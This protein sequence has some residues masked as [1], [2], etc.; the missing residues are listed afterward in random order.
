MI[1]A[2]LTAVL[3]SI[4]TGRVDT[5][6][7]TLHDESSADEYPSGHDGLLM[8][9]RPILCAECHA[10]NALGAA[11]V[12]GV[13]SLS[14]AIHDKHEGEVPDSQVGCYECHPGPDT[15]CLR[16]V[17]ST[18]HDMGCVDCHGGMEDVADNP[19]P[20]LNEPRCDTCHDEPG[21]E[22]NQ[23]L[24]R[25]STDHGGLY[26]AAC[27]DSPHA[28]APSREAVDGIKFVDLQGHPGTLSTC[29]VCH[30]TSPTEAGPHGI[31]EVPTA[32]GLSETSA[33]NNATTRTASVVTGGCDHC[34]VFGLVSQETRDFGR[35]RKLNF[36]QDNLTLAI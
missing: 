13:P 25:L 32:V 8:D 3:K 24:Y 30:A 29:T 35:I 36:N 22:Q 33:T 20:W 28:I 11:G 23:D 9:R 2:T 15:A 1:I 10:S 21:Y 27:H 34:V 12:A 17:M 5:N 6:I 31:I 14:N 7:L 4:A 18:D 26:C 19:N 16:D